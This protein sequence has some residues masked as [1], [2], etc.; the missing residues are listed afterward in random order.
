MKDRCMRPLVVAVMLAVAALIAPGLAA[1][2]VLPNE[3]ETFASGTTTCTYFSSSSFVVPAGVTELRVTAA[4]EPGEPGD[5]GQYHLCLQPRPGTARRLRR[6]RFRGH[7]DDPRVARAGV[8]CR[9]R[10]R[11]S[12]EVRAGMGAPSLSRAVPM[13]RRRRRRGRRRRRR[14][15]ADSSGYLL[16]GA[17]GGG[18]GGGGQLVGDGGA[19]GA[20]GAPGAVGGGLF[21]AAGG[22]AG[23]QAGF[24]GEAGGDGSGQTGAG[25]GGGGSG[26]KGG[27]RGSGSAGDGGGGGGG[28][29]NLVPSGGTVE[30][31]RDRTVRSDLLQH[32]PDHRDRHPSGRPDRRQR[33]V[34][35]RCN[36]RRPGAGVFVFRAGCRRDALRPRPAGRRVSVR[37]P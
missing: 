9:R 6:C 5:R 4:G 31:A 30:S 18:G 27:G 7:R 12:P 14:L 22:F 34:Q 23:N 21:G 17:G 8:P 36:P 28:G 19:G 35:V 37:R 32:S 15:A 16:I 2:D 25:G 3:C 13:M 1:G 10:H 29:T 24:I 11:P 20:T 33:L 26:Y